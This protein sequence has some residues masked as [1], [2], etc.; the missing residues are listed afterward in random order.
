MLKMI[1]ISN[2]RICRPDRL[3]DAKHLLE[4]RETIERSRKLLEEPLPST[5]L[6]L[7]DS[8]SI[9]PPATENRRTE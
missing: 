3:K 9:S 2:A 4:A 8:I 7:R 1:P 6:G 5:F